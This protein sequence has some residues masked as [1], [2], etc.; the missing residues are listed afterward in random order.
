MTC[1]DKDGM[2]PEQHKVVYDNY[3][4][5]YRETQYVTT[6]TKVEEIVDCFKHDTIYSLKGKMK[7]GS[8]TGGRKNLWQKLN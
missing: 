7:Y 1:G 4:E 6:S 5:G 8:T 2:V 3:A